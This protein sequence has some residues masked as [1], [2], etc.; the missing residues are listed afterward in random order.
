ML[1]SI[2]WLTLSLLTQLKVTFQLNSQTFHDLN[3]LNVSHFSDCAL[4]QN[5][6]IVIDY[7]SE[8]VDNGLYLLLINININY[9]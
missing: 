6:N 2:V 5:D 3:D 7:K 1:L 4:N 9:Y 8:I